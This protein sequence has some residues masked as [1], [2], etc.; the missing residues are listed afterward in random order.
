MKKAFGLIE[1]LIASAIIATILGGLVFVGRYTMESSMNT[2]T[3]SEALALATEGIE[4]VRQIRDTNWIDTNK[5][6]SWNTLVLESTGK[7]LAVDLSKD[8]QVHYIKTDSGLRYGLSTG[9]GE[10]IIL[11]DGSVFL[12][13]I[14][15]ESPGNLVKGE[16]GQIASSDN[17]MRVTCQV[18]WG[19]NHSVVLS[20]LLTNWK[21]NY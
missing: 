6:T 2:L 3:R 20:E 15:F 7:F 10:K 5:D 17:A 16:S 11:N 9:N 13:T 21:P 18:S 12:R 4:I 19:D 8:Y 14:S 1:V